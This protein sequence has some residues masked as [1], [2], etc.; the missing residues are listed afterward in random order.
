[1]RYAFVSDIHGNLPA[2]N[3]VLAEIALR[4]IDRIICLGDI[5]GYGP[6]PADVLRSVYEKSH[7]IVLGN[8]DAVVGGRMDPEAFNDRA[9]AMICWTKDRLGPRAAALF[10]ELPLVIK[11]PSFMAAHANFTDP[12]AFDYVVDEETAL[13]NFRTTTEPLLFIGHSHRPEIFVFNAAKTAATATAHRIDPTSFEV[14]PGKRYIVN[15]GSVGYS[16]NADP[17]ATFVIYDDCADY[18]RAGDDRADDDCTDYNSAGDDRTDDNRTNETDETNGKTATVEFVSVPY[19]F[20][21]LRA[22]AARAGLTQNEYPLLASASSAAAASVRESFDFAASDSRATGD[23]SAQ[24]L[25]DALRLLRTQ[26]ATTA[27][28]KRLALALIILAAIAAIAVSAAA[29]MLT[30]SD[31]KSVV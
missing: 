30:R 23:A 16:R 5:V 14:E 2:W 19:D 4:R 29:A 22:A 27:R 6:Q 31:R 18:D 21:S 24:S 28:W 9:R 13:A 15:I 20:E 25:D 12:A 3:T 8:H 17:R 26:T 1:M 10:K 11:G 7:S